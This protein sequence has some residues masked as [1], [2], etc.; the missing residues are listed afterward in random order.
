MKKDEIA[1]K[2]KKRKNEGS[3]EKQK[4]DIKMLIAKGIVFCKKQS[5][6]LNIKGLKIN[7]KTAQ[8]QET[9]EQTNKNQQ[10]GV[11]MEHVTIT[12]KLVGSYSILIAC[13][14]AVG[15]TAY[16]VASNA[17]IDSYKNATKQSLD[18]LGEYI[19]Y[20]FENV[21]SE[22]VVY[23]VDEEMMLYVAGKMDKGEQL[24]YFNKQKTNLLNKATVDLF[25]GNI[26]F[27]SDDAPALTTAK[28]SIDKGYSFYTATE[29]GTTFMEDQTKC[30]LGASSGLD[31]QMQVDSDSYA[32]RL[33][34]QFYKKNA[35]LIIDID[36]QAIVDSLNRIQPGEGSG[37]V[38]ITPDG[39]ELHQDGSR[40]S[41]VTGTEFYA[42]A[43]ASE[44]VQGVVEDVEY[45]GKKS[46]F[47]YRKIG[48]TGCIVCALIPNAIVTAQVSKIRWVVI[49]GAMISCLL[50]IAVAFAI[51]AG[52]HKTVRHMIK[53]M[54]LIAQ[55]N[56]DVRM[57]LAGKSEFAQISE[58]MNKM[59]DSM[60]SLLAGVKKV[61]LKVADSAGNVNSSS[62][63]IKES[64]IYISNAMNDIEN[65]LSSQADDTISCCGQLD[66]LAGSIGE[67]AER[68]EDIREIAGNTEVY[69]ENSRSAINS[70]KEK[71][72]ETSQ[73][74]YDIIGA[75]ENLR[76]KSSKIDQIIQ[77]VY[78]IADETSLLSLNASIE[79]ARAGAQGKGFQVIAEEI[80]KLAD[81]SMTATK[82][83]G[84]IVSDI[85][86]TTVQ[87]VETAGK[88]GETINRQEEAVDSALLAFTNMVEQLGQLMEKV[89]S[90]TQSA[91][92]MGGQKEEALRN[93]ESIS[94][95]TQSA[96]DAVVSVNEKT[97]HQEAEVQKLAELSKEMEKQVKEL[98]ESLQQFKLG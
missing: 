90:I 66:G 24:S 53:N 78:D 96:V 51:S 10:S 25:I 45:Q 55:G 18:M 60:T 23:L 69:I 50:A 39:R 41:L 17:L 94:E 5:K 72:E 19:E 31:T 48:D 56:M 54:R 1:Q 36:K 92:A 16:A 11:R 38:F 35:L 71:A 70:L 79:A 43:M 9:G 47:L 75:I 3:K 68:S 2:L 40:E 64:T 58:Q 27:L 93:M 44:E 86:S 29:Q 81:Q 61:S 8:G 88:A 80:R 85:S 89:S 13:I 73:I 20:G 76:M 59:L 42:N 91:V 7:K 6:K 65:G 62:S 67:V 84:T 22:A 14:L 52:I 74:T 46:L 87:A 30:W 83:I 34:K 12:G 57:K 33:V 21:N 4:I 28:Q 82:E 32:V 77:T 37:L 98:E 26:S 49:G 95:V 97:V 63:A 15:L